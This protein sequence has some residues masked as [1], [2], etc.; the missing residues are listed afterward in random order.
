[1]PELDADRLEVADSVRRQIAIENELSRQQARAYVRCLQT[2][3][4]VPTIQWREQES[5]RQL[6][7]ARRLLHAAQIFRQIEGT[8]SSRAI[9]C[10]RRAGEILEWL[11]RASDPVR[12][13][14]PIELLAAAAYQLGGLPAMATGLLGQVESE[15][16]GVALY[17]AFLRAD[18][19]DVIRRASAFWAANPELTRRDSA[20]RIAMPDPDEELLGDDDRVVWYFTVELVRSLGL[21]AD[22]LRRGRA[23]RLEV[24]Q[25]K[26]VALDEMAIRTF[27][28]DASLLISLMRL[29]A[30]SYRT[31]SIYRPLLELAAM[32]P[33][34]RTRLET[35]AR[36]Q[37]RRGR[38]ILWTSQLQGLEPLL[39]DSSFALCTPTGSGK[40]L[41]ANMALI[42]ELLLQNDNELAP[43]AIYLVPSRAL[44]GEVEAKLRSELGNDMT[45]TALYGGADWGIT[46]YWLTGDQPTV[47]IATVEKAEALMR[48][49]G[50]ILTARLRLLI[51]DEAHQVVPE[52]GES[53][54][55]SFA[56]HSNRSLRLESLVSRVMA[57]RPNVVRMRASR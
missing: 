56:E 28:D 21:I 53:T 3:W 45:I 19:D 57:Q 13:I 38:G 8:T 26:L 22:S 39:R 30:E 4:D 40:T 1:V 6:S 23:E 34:R 29:V 44:A 43:L 49:L 36:D 41:V 33:D 55:V 12:G 25:A 16:D 24:A 32:D 9:D 54:R 7:D 27:S 46:D 18:F 2:T 50:P 48:Y 5:A 42:K 14:V 20:F 51:L 31:A 52:G 15:N 37:F 11:T 35:Y 47:L 10:Y 17:A